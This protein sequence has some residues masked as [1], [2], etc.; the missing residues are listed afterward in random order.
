VIDVMI[1]SAVIASGQAKATRMTTEAILP[2]ATIS[3]AVVARAATANQTLVK[4]VIER[5]TQ[6]VSLVHILRSFV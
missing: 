3:S 5:S 6:Q 1:A 4:R 2:A